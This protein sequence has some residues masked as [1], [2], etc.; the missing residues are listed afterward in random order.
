MK[1]LAGFSSFALLVGIGLIGGTSKEVMLEAQAIPA[2]GAQPVS[3]TDSGL[4]DGRVDW[5]LVPN[6]KANWLQPLT[7]DAVYWATVRSIPPTALNAT[8]NMLWQA[9]D[10]SADMTTY[11]TRPVLTFTRTASGAP[12]VTAENFKTQAIARIGGTM[13]NPAAPLT[14]YFWDNNAPAANGGLSCSSQAGH[15]PM[16]RV[17]SSTDPTQPMDVYWT[18]APIPDRYVGSTGF[19]PRLGNGESY[20][21]EADQL[22]GNIYILSGPG[23]YIDNRNITGGNRFAASTQN[24]WIFLVWNPETG[25]YSLS[26]SP[27]PGD[28]YQGMQTVPQE[29]VKVRAGSAD[30]S[31][32]AL[33]NASSDFALD[34]DGNIYAYSGRAVTTTNERNMSIVR[35]EPARDKQGNIIDGTASNPWRYFVSAKIRRDPTQRVGWQAANSIY[36]EAFLNGNLLL[37]ASTGITGIASLN[38]PA[39]ATQGYAGTTSMVKINPLTSIAS[40][41]WS[42]QNDGMP[43]PAT[44]EADDNASAQQAQVI[45]GYLYDDA[46]G[47]GVISDTEKY[48]DIDGDGVISEDEMD[49]K[50]IPD[51]NVALYDSS[52]TL[53]SVQQTDSSGRYDFIVTG[54]GERT[55][56]VRPVQI[57]A[58]LADGVTMVNAV[59]TWG[60]GSTRSGYSATGVELVNQVAVQCVGASPITSADGAACMG[61]KDPSS[62]DLPLATDADGNFILGGT[63]SPDQWLSYATATLRTDQQ[64]PTA[65]FGYTTVGSYGDSMAGPDT[66]NVPGHINSVSSVWL[67]ANPGSYTGPVTDD[68]HASDDGVFIQSYAGDIPLQDTLVSADRAYTLKGVLSGNQ[69]A[70]ASVTGWLGSGITWTP[71]PA[72]TT[73]VA[74]GVATGEV[75]FPSTRT[76]AGASTV[77]FRADASTASISTPTN[78]NN[79]YYAN[80]SGVP[81]W[82]TPGEIE[83]YSVIVGDSVYRP[84][85][86][87][88]GGSGTFQ[89]DGQTLAANNSTYTI[90]SAKPA[91]LGSEKSITATAPDSTWVLQSA[92]IK[93]ITTGDVLGEA[94][95]STTGLTTAIWWTPQLGEDVIIDL[96]YDKLPDPTKS[97]LVLDK[98]T[99]NVGGTITGTVTVRDTAN[100]PL[101]GQLVLFSKASADT[102]ISRSVCLTDA[103]GQCVVT[104]TSNKAKVYTDEL[105]ATVTVGEDQRD[106][107]GSPATVTFL[108]DKGDPGQ[109]SLSLDRTGPQ[110]VGTVITATATVKDGSGNPVAG[111]DVT[112]SVTMQGMDLGSRICTTDG[113]GTCSITETSPIPG[114]FVV[115][116]KIPSLTDGTLTNIQNSPQMVTFVAGPVCVV[117][118]G[119]TPDPGVTNITHVEV[120]SDEMANDG[121]TPDVITAYT[122]DKGGNP[123]SGTL[124]ITTDDDSLTLL[125]DRIVTDAAT[126]EGILEATSTVAGPH[127]ARAF[128][129]GTELR[130]HG[131]PLTLTFLVGAAE[132]LKSTLTVSPSTQT[133]GGAVTASAEARDAT[134]NLV[135][136]ATIT[137]SVSGSASFTGQNRCTTTEDGTCSVTFTDD[138]A[139]QVS[140]HGMLGVIDIIDSPQ[141]V[142]FTADEVC[143]YPQCTPDPGVDNAHRTRVEVAPNDQLV[144][145]GTDVATVY[146]FDKH[147]NPVVNAVVDSTTD[148]PGLVIGTSIARTSGQGT[149]TVSYTSSVRGGHEAVV[150]VGG[151]EVMYLPQGASEPDP[152]KSSPITLNFTSGGVCIAPSCTPDPDV[153]NAHRTRVEVSLNDQSVDG[154]TDV[155]TVYAF[156][157]QGQPIS[158]AAVASATTDPALR[159]SS[160]IAPTNAQGV[161]TISYNAASVG[162][163]TATVTIN[164]TE[165]KYLPQGETSI[166]ESK[167]SPIT[168]NF[169][170]GGVCIA[171]DCTPNPDVDNAHRTR[172]EVSLDGQSA[173]GGAD[174][175]TVYAF[176]RTGMPVAGAVVTSTTA[177]ATLIVGSDIA[178]T[179][180]QGTSLISYTSDAAGYHD[181]NVMINGT[182]V[183][184][185]PQGASA[186]DPAKSSPIRLTF[187]AGGVCV[188]P[189]CTPDPGVD[190]AHRTRVE[191]TKDLQSVDGGTDEATAYAFDRKGNPIESA[192]VT[193]TTTDPALTIGTDIPATDSEGLSVISYTSTLSGAHEATV[194]IN[195]AEVKFIPQGA[196]EPDEAMSSP[197][198]PEF[199]SGGVCVYPQCTPDPGVDNDHRTRVEV[200][201]DGESVD[202][203]SDEA[204]VYAF[205]Q[206]GNPVVGSVVASTTADPALSVADEI[207]V[208]DDYGESV[209]SYTS[210]ASGGHE[211]VVTIDGNEVKFVPQG[212]TAPDP[213]MSSPIRVTFAAAG[214]CVAPQCV[215][216]PNVDNAHRTRVEVTQDLASVD[217]GTDQATVYAFDKYGNPVEGASVASA[218]D[219]PALSVGTG[220]AATDSR[221]ESVVS[222]T[223]TVAGSH[224][225]AVTIDGT[226]ITFIPQGGSVR[227]PSMS[228]PVQLQFVVGE[229]CV[230]PQCTPDPS[231]DNDHRTRVEVTTDSQSVDGGVDQATVYAFDKHGNAIVGATVTSS[232]TDAKLVIGSGIAMTDAQ[233]ESVVSYTSAASGQHEATVRVN[234][235]EVKYVPQDATAPD[236]AK[237]SPITLT[238]LAGG[239]CVAPACTPD[240]GVDNDHRTRVEVA[241]NDQP[242]G[243]TDVATVY[244]FDKHGNA[245][246]D[247]VV[248]STTSDSALTI[249]TDIAA[250]NAQGRSTVSYTSTVAGSHQAVVTA[251]GSEVKY[252]PQGGTQVDPAKSSPIELRF[253]AAGIC[254]APDCTPEPSVDNAH[255]TR[256]EVDPNDQPV[257]GTDVATV[258]AFDRYGNA[259]ADA[260]VASTTSD[261]AL[262]IGPDIP[263]TNASGT[264]TVRY[265]SIV[266]GSHEAAVTIDGTPV[267]YLPQGATEPDPAKSSPIEL[268]FVAGEACVAPDCT[269]DENVDNA[270]RTRVEVTTDYATVGT[271]TDVATVYVFDQHG[272]AVSGATVASASDDAALVI[273]SPVAATN[274]Q[275]T[276]TVTYTSNVA[277]E[278]SAQVT[279]NG[280]EVKFVPQ[281]QTE[282]DPAKSSPITLHFA[283]GEVCVYPDCV[284]DESVDNAHRT[285]VEVT[286]DYATAG[287]GTDVATVYVFDKQGNAISGAGVASTTV[288]A[289]LVIGSPIAATNAQGISTV[290]YT[291]SVAGEHAAAVTVN[292]K[293]VAY[294]P[295]GETQPDPAKSSPIA[296]HFVAGEVC[297]APDCV[298]DESV[299][300]A[301]RTRVEVTTD[302]QMVNTGTDVATVYV[303][304][305]YGNP[306]SDAAVASTTNDAALIIGA[307]I[308]ATDAHGTST[309]SY[310]SAAGGAHQAA[311]TVNGKEIAYLPQ[312]AAQVDPSKSS[313][314]TVTFVVLAIKTGGTAEHSSAALLTAM[315]AMM[316]AGTGCVAMSV[317]RKAGNR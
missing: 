183:S 110:P 124:Q 196:T 244:V 70:N 21:G 125:G 290:N 58:P 51:Q 63:S 106:V 273:G 316:V 212:Q 133:V 43:S 68:S 259:V 91:A 71:A 172:V 159:I 213:A 128:V 193:S 240:P 299:D 122:Y 75:T 2:A 186:P 114:L 135:E 10:W 222:Y 265:T 190:N 132:P 250:T 157:Q 272:N 121:V 15:T 22:T 247:V 130:Q 46:N 304:D 92:M 79:E 237:S 64:V 261:S 49:P 155:A 138:T 23:G 104:I 256:V 154:G 28:W 77:L 39:T 173:D 188:A 291:S 199:V 257:Q 280:K 248:A 279:V 197:I 120:T 171:P 139:E 234:G 264:S 218:T 270:H 160:P 287:T 205:D 94:E 204:T 145:T 211:A 17:T 245:V 148:D 214:V 126:G 187:V 296:L 317:R 266:A 144:G 9:Y 41:V 282:P 62:P 180:A 226:E 314:I 181:A 52:Y 182:L 235:S 191:V 12:S 206:H 269:P 86:M 7:D 215:P 294:V 57:Q 246:Q 283:T 26:G 179:N 227:D 119:C 224:E 274:A 219:D 260:V 69:A 223:A 60:A 281:D 100:Q 286:T 111:Q 101:E 81:S 13:N 25:V 307:G 61:A 217:G 275:G 59:Q 27:Q 50:G 116:A 35:L 44:A 55:Y 300:N 310:A 220:I 141:A 297:I 175:A 98:D 184:Y 292:G 309:V 167:S 147:G 16:I 123:T 150:T 11:K 241:P 210:N 251:G 306:I 143:V 1:L 174:Q 165:V 170:V 89:V 268:R 151:A 242:V 293:P 118:L 209:V 20:G 14:I 243:G 149:S 231:V 230:Y 192:V 313:P 66:V 255:R 24:Q 112:I 19:A 162:E 53:L 276:S 229:V 85:V 78:A 34:A 6:F 203:G 315:L 96:V 302:N 153:D 65:D 284:P 95:T 5:K 232:T 18:C 47:D 113:T 80:S 207:P 200:T 177:D 134:D 30:D 146:A 277:G 29:R 88:T 54:S 137:F 142:T 102:T 105:T 262:I 131:S 140:V 169:I 158:G 176:D 271:G 156:D 76:V 161:S 38:P 32:S 278:H 201:K 305:K 195:G 103:D 73:T 233:G 295:Q 298:P 3:H 4:V 40:V 254:I 108:A 285:R 185:L 311:V 93:D 48:D 56:Y 164:G 236:P 288:D 152:S 97:E 308:A 267:A 83:D 99:V 8:T 45:S 312:G 208:T 198:W 238:F 189:D 163:H 33:P 87:T 74:G 228:S 216:D 136:G 249:S 84:A 67:G 239:I 252:I 263:A 168:L 82:T 107:V 115:S 253:V 127:T 31:T 72:W 303:F 42:I 36:G 258:Y 90:G 129:D 117:E 37:G 202:G 221:G 289:A 109:S 194:S 166:D 225:A 301:H 178:P